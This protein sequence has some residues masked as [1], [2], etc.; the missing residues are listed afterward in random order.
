MKAF[1]L[2]KKRKDG[3]LGSLFINARARHPIGVWMVAEAHEKKGYAYRPGWHVLLKQEAPHLTTKN[4]IWCEV[5]V[6][7]YEEFERPESQGG[8]WIL[9]QRMKIIREIES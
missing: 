3:S 7:D 6:E 9:A 5:E 2:I 4:R 8:K 1:K